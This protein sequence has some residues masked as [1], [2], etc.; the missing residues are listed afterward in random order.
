[1]GH[2]SL[3]LPLLQRAVEQKPSAYVIPLQ[4]VFDPPIFAEGGS[5]EK[6]VQKSCRPEFEGKKGLKTQVMPLRV[7]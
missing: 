1:L 5:L 4:V 7:R 2:R 6:V 3:K